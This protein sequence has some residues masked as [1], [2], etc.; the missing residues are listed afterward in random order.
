MTRERVDEILNL[1]LK[2]TKAHHEILAFGLC[3][4]W[5]RGTAKTDS[6]I[7]LS[8][9]VKDKSRFKKTDWLEKINFNKLNESIYYYHDKIYG[10]TWSR[11]VILNSHLEIEFGFAEQPWANTV[12]IDEGTRKVVSDGYEIIFDP[13]QILNKLVEQIKIENSNT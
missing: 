12:D 6:D 13:H 10:V 1:I 5:A 2:F 7:D 11:H 9:I 8:L 3:G 4:S